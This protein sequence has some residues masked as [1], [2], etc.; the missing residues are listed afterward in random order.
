MERTEREILLLIYLD[1]PPPA[2]KIH[3]CCRCAY[4]EFCWA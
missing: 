3:W 4:A 2:E 1:A